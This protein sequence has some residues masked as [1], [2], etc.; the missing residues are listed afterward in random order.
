MK[1][2]IYIFVFFFAAAFSFSQSVNKAIPPRPQPPQLVNDFTNTLT[3]DQAATLEKKLEAFDKA[4]STQIA[5][6]IINSLN[7]YDVSD[8]ALAIL[9]NWGVGQKNKNNGVVLLIA[10][11]DR[12]IDINTGYG[13]EGSLDDITAKH[14]ID[15]DIVPL[16][17]QKDYYGGINAGTDKIIKAV[18]G[19]YTA[20]PGYGEIKISTWQIIKIILLIILILYLFSRGSGNGGSFMSRRGYRGWGGNTIFWP[21]GGWGGG[22]RGGWSGGGGF[23]GF[24]GGSGGGGGASGSW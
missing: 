23:G 13:L 19:E 1:K 12:K 14:I 3:A 5:V 17:K 9:R 10:K 8:Y 24:G 6:V 4:S 21:G 7:G 2:I 18:R 11:K 16:F 15:E 22:G 20:P